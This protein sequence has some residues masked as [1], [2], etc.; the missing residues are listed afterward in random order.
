MVPALDLDYSL[1]NISINIFLNHLC[2]IIILNHPIGN[3]R[4]SF[5]IIY[6]R[7]HAMYTFVSLW[8][9]GNYYICILY[10]LILHRWNPRHVLNYTMALWYYDDIGS[11]LFIIVRRNDPVKYVTNETIRHPLLFF[12][13]IFWK[14]QHDYTY[15]RNILV[16]IF[17]STR[18]GCKTIFVS[19]VRIIITLRLMWFFGKSNVECYRIN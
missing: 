3:I 10:L 4:V 1:L 5:F 14:I 11:L 7:K 2:T 13:W 6:S 18:V 9:K 8:Y 19:P 17:M 15:A 12:E 16:H